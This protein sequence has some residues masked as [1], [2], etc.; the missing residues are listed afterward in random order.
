MK[1]RVK[2]KAKAEDVIRVADR[3][4]DEIEDFHKGSVLVR[5]RADLGIVS[6]EIM[7][8]YA[9]I[10]YA[11]NDAALISGL[12]MGN[13]CHINSVIITFNKG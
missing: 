13:D 9:H 12:M 3:L 1:Y 10:G 4:D 6:A 7:K 5:T 11:M 8:D 2:I